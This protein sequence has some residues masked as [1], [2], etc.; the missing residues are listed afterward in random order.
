[1]EKNYKLVRNFISEEEKELIIK[2]VDSLEHNISDPNYHL[3]ELSKS[4][5]GK[6][7]IFDISQ[8]DF[9]KYISKFQSVSFINSC[10]SSM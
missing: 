7:C 10:S 5:N 3:S 2:W 4:L 1:M 9:T 6:S 8:T